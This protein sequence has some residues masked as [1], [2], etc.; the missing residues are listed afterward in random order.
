[1][2][3]LSLEYFKEF[4]ERKLK[5]ESEFYP[6]LERIERKLDAT[7]DW[8]NRFAKENSFYVQHDTMQYG[9]GKFRTLPTIDIEACEKRNKDNGQTRRV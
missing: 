4:A 6:R 1:M 7:I 8:I 9:E 5:E 3:I 2:S